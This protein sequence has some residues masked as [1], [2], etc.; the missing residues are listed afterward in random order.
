MQS[1]VV[2]ADDL[3]A[4]RSNRFALRQVGCFRVIATVDGRTSVRPTIARLQPHVVLVNEMCQRMNLM[5]RIREAAEA[6]PGAKIVYLAGRV[7]DAAVDEAVDAGAHVVIARDLPPSVL[8]TVLREA[9]QGNVAM[10]PRASAHQAAAGQAQL[11]LLAR[12]SA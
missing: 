2:V 10:S 1:L 4:V 7:D 12:T 8:G 11:A 3:A 6:A 9:V 5:S